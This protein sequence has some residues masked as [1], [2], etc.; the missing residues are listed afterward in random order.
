MTTKQ[1][2]IEA[3]DKVYDMLDVPQDACKY[4]GELYD[5]IRSF[6]EKEQ[7]CGAVGK[8][9]CMKYDR[10][11][12]GCSMKNV[13]YT[14]GSPSREWILEDA[15]TRENAVPS[16]FSHDVN[17][18]R[19]SSTNL[20]DEVIE[21]IKVAQETIEN[22]TFHANNDTIN[23]EEYYRG[24]IFMLETL[25]KAAQSQRVEEVKDS[26]LALYISCAMPLDTEGD[27]IK[28]LKTAI[29]KVFKYYPHGLRIIPDNAEG[30]K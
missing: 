25:I 30:E 4:T 2:A 10:M 28:F 22:L 6:I 24:K 18:V 16:C 29:Q 12:E 15:A 11:G 3:L 7:C 23:N 20:S 14:D 17:S 9:A 13:P 21:A 19:T 8:E 1:E 27:R 5:T 26:R